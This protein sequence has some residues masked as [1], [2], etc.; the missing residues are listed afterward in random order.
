MPPLV[1]IRAELVAAAVEQRADDGAPARVH[2]RQAARPG[3]AQQPQQKRLGL[4]VARVADGHDVR[5]EMRTRPLEEGVARGVRRVLERAALAFA[6][7]PR[8]SSRSTRTG[9]PSVPASDAQN[10]SSRSAPDTPAASGST[11]SWWLKC[12]SPATRQLAGRVELAQ[13]VRERH[14]IRAAR[15]RDHDARPGA[16][17]IVAAKRAPDRCDHHGLARRAGRVGGP[18]T[19]KGAARRAAC[20]LARPACP[21]RPACISRAIPP[22]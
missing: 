9:R 5:V 16:S 6:R 19:T 3:A 1:E 21:A 17:Q 4:I 15:Q 22:T 2:G 13:Q 7:A 10:R 14:R 12:A 8:T 18:V 20:G 11:R